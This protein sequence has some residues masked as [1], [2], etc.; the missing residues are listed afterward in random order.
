[1]SVAD[2]TGALTRSGAGPSD[3]VLVMEARAGEA[4]AQEA[5]FRRYAPMVNGLAFRLLGG[6]AD[7]DDL[8]QDSFA[9]A[10]TSLGRLRNN[11]VFAS[12]ISTIV[13]RTANK[14]LRRRRLMNRLGLRR[15][16]PIDVESIHAKG[17]PAD[18]TVELRVLYQLVENMPAKLRIP[19][20]L[21]H[22]EDSSLEEIA[23]LTGVS[24]ATVKRRLTEAQAMLDDAL[25]RST[26]ERS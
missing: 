20:L 4:W 7:L 24:L 12:W 11:E 3:A 25:A 14:L 19:L 10:L 8:V 16:Q 6:D 23:R 13:V 22:L 15:S 2:A 21:R 17:T 26:G 5:L 9:Q 18:V 1:L